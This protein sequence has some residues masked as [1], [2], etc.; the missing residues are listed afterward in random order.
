MH[1]VTFYALALQVHVPQLG[2]AK[3]LGVFICTHYIKLYKKC[4]MDNCFNAK[5]YNFIIKC[6]TY[7]P[8][9]Y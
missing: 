7:D 1:L 9:Q 8:I 5:S 2:L 4:Q 6:F 3:F